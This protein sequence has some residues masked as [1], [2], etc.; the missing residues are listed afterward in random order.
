[1]EAFKITTREHHVIFHIPYE[2]QWLE[3]WFTPQD[4]ADFYYQLGTVLERMSNAAEGRMYD[5]D[6]FTEFGEALT[7][8]RSVN[9]GEV[10]A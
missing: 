5:R 6:L 1:M 4:A 8:V 3:W 7:R 9:V 10:E 2:G